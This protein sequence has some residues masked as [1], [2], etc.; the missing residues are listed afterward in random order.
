MLL[1]IS[2]FGQNKIY[3][4][5][6]AIEQ[7][8]QA[9]TNFDYLREAPIDYAEKSQLTKGVK[10]AQIFEVDQKLLKNFVTK[11]S[12][13]VKMDLKDMDGKPMRLLLTQSKVFTPDFN[14]YNSANPDVP[15]TYD[16]GVHYRGIIE[17]DQNSVVAISVFNDQIMGLILKDQS[18]YVL[19]KLQ[20]DTEDRHI[21][22]KDD[23]LEEIYAFECGTF[24]D[25]EPY[26]KED[27]EDNGLSQAEN[28]GDCIRVYVEIDNDIVT[29]KGGAVNA[30]NYVTGLFNQVIVMYANENLDMVV[31]EIFAWTNTSPY[32]SSSSSGMLSDF[33]SNIGTFNGDLAHLLSYQASGGI[34]AGFSGICNNN[35]DESMCFSSI[36]ATYSNVPTYS[37]SVM[38]VTHEMGHLIGSR[39]THAC[40]WNGNNTA[41]DGCSGSTEG[42]C[43][44]PG[45]PSGGGTAMSYCHITNVGIN[46]NLGFGT[47]PGNVIRNTVA[48]ASCLSACGP[49]CNDGIQNGGETGVD[50]G[51]PDCPACPTCNDGIQNGGETGVDCGGPDCAPCAP[52]Y[53]SANGTNTNYEYIETVVIGNISNNSG[54]D[55]GYADYTSIS[56]DL[57]PGS[58][59]TASLTPGFVNTSYNEYWAIY[60]DYNGDYDFD[61]AGERV[62]TGSGTSTVTISFAVPS[63][64]SGTTRMRVVMDYS[65]NPPN[66]CGSFTYGEVED[67][68]V[69]LS[70]SGPTCNDGIQNGSET[71]VDCGGPDCPACPTCSD[72]IQNGSET[73]VDCGGPDCPACDSCNDGIQNGSE[74]GVD[75]GGPNC[76]ACDS[77]NDGVQNGSETGVDCGGPDCPACDSCNDGVQNGSE[78]GVDCGG[79]DCPAC[80]SCNDGIQNGSETGVDCGGPDCPACDSCNDGIQNGSE[81]GVDCGGP[82]CAPCPSNGGQIFAHYF[83]SGWDGWIDGGSDCYRYNSSTYAWEGVRSIRLRDNSGVASS[84]TLNN[85]DVSGNTSLTFSFFFRARSM[86]FGEDFWVRINDGSGWQTIAVYA[87]GTHFN[88]NTFYQVVLTISSVDYNLS[89]DMDFRIQC[90]ASANGDQIYVDQVELAGSGA[91]NLDEGPKDPVITAVESK[92]TEKE[93]HIENA[94]ISISVYPN[95][96]RDLLYFNTITEIQTVDIFDINGQLISKGV[97]IGIDNSIDISNLNEGIYI[98]HFIENG[99]RIPKKFIK[100]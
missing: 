9:F 33:Q 71:G 80:D 65:N 75:C 42:S 29:Q 69:S 28:V 81:T 49:G 61:D 100:M 10:D 23:E 7:S 67:Y 39:H 19:G 63:N 12:K 94:P 53:C 73:G 88:N 77:C 44:L 62:G 25:D 21:L 41:I 31:S 14:L 85:V 76:P 82:D 55:G 86:E 96:A 3:Q 64:A 5:I 6:Q 99:N 83:E 79:P 95:P 11:K 27:L 2:L 58:S 46:L 22:Y 70:G 60:I 40:V 26:T 34:A 16:G 47:Q 52:E 90:D 13:Q 18:N 8:P 93:D 32:S 87:R 30:T 50:C 89:G 36:D 57:N 78:T 48:N 15:M 59:Y 56:T 35:P 4:Q 43:A 68:T 17:G 1:P 51:G 74:T 72:G 84:M 66:Q 97:K 92:V 24:D 54:S 38:V 98:I 45:N 20:E 91:G 37:W